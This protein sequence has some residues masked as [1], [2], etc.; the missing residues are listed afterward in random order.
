[1]IPTFANTPTRPPAHTA[2]VNSVCVSADGDCVVSGSEDRTVRLWRISSR[3]CFKVGSAALGSVAQRPAGHLFLCEERGNKLLKGCG[4]ANTLGACSTSRPARP[5]GARGAHGR[6][7][8]RGDRGRQQRA[9]V[10][11]QGHNDPHVP[12]ARRVT[13]FLSDTA[14]T[15]YAESIAERSLR[16][17]FFHQIASACAAVTVFPSVFSHFKSQG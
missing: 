14:T 6:D 5:A 2:R 13:F 10:G 7:H 16:I 4:V 1:L 15:T 11:V 8:G 17:T 3:E 12:R 9:C